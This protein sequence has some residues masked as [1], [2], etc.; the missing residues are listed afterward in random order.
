MTS[1][2]ATRHLISLGDASK[3]V[4]AWPPICTMLLEGFCDENPVPANCITSDVLYDSL[5]LTISDMTGVIELSN[6]N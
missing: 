4:H 5:W 2:D 6:V 1:I 3:V